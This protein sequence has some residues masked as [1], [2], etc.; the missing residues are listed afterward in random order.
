MAIKEIKVSP[1][2][3]KH[4][5]KLPNRIKDKAKEKEKIFRKNPFHPVFRYR[6]ARYL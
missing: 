5:K 1:L 6:P 2:F 4:Y 3:E